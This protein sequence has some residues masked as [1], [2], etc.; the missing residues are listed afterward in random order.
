MQ[1][2]HLNNWKNNEDENES[3]VANQRAKKIAARKQSTSSLM[4]SSSIAFETS[5]ASASLVT[6]TNKGYLPCY[7]TMENKHIFYY[8]IVHEKLNRVMCPFC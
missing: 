1:K 7:T 3:I 2:H 8:K 6:E 4:K 5:R